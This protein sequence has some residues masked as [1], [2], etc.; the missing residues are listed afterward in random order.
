MLSKLYMIFLIPSLSLSTPNDIKILISI[1]RTDGLIWAFPYLVMAV[2][3]MKA[4]IL[5]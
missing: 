5:F 3:S 4:L 1:R 2:N